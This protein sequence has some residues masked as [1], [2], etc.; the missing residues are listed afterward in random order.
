[1]SRRRLALLPVLGLVAA[2]CGSEAAVPG[3]QPGVEAERGAWRT[4]ELSADPGADQPVVFAADGDQVVAVVVSEDGVITGFATDESGNFVGGEPTRSETEQLRLGGV[5][6]LG[7][8]W[9]AIGTGGLD[10]VDGNEQLTFQ[11]R[12]YSTPDGR[13]WSAGDASGLGGPADVLDVQGTS[14]GGVVAVGNSRSE[15]DPS[16]G[17]FEPRAWFRTDGGA[18]QTVDLPMNGARE[19]HAGAVASVGDTLL[20]VGALDGSGAMWSSEDDGA[21]WVITDAPGLPAST[22]A[23]IAVSDDTLVVS[24][25]GGSSDEK[26]DRPGVLARSVDGGVSWSP[27]VEPPPDGGGESFGNP[28]FGG[29]GGA[30]LTT[31]STFIE[32]FRQPEL[33]YADIDLCRQDTSVVLYASDDGDTWRRIDTSG[34]GE[35]EAREVDGAVVA[36]DGRIVVHQGIEGGVRVSTWPAAAPLPG[37]EE[38]VPP[39]ADLVML[40]EGQDPEIGIRYAV[41]LYIHCGMHYLYLGDAPWQRTDHGPDVETGAGDAVTADWPEAQQTIF[42]YATRTDAETVEYSIADGEVIATY[43]PATGAI[44]GCA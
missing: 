18:W 39:T 14:G 36:D 34:L 44:P 32:G 16:F 29:N 1:M 37:E 23:D 7:D 11:V 27:V 40:E 41:P 20:A 42:G 17:G 33:C 30:F 31:T 24:G 43:A 10:E 38:P 19:G 25:V 9:V 6:R 22:L 26:G 5:A 15:Q 35:G 4:Q 3:E 8:E 28:I 12:V 13:T 2:A 21:T